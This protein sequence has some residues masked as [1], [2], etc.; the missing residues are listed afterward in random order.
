MNEPRDSATLRFD[1]RVAIVT[2]AGNGLGR[3]HALLLGER[4]AKVVVNDVGTN[5]SGRG[6]A[7][8]PADAVVNEIGTGGGEAVANYESVEDG[9]RIVETALDHFGRIDIVVNNAGILRDRAFHNMTEQEWDEIYRVHVLGAFRVTRAAWPHLRQARY[10]RVVFT[11][12]GS[13]VY[14]NFGQA[15]YAMAKLGLLGLAQTLAVEGRRRNI[16]VNTIAP[17]AGTRMPAMLWPPEVVEALR[18]ELVSPAVVY[19]CHESCAVSGALFEIGGGW[20]ARLRWQRSDGV[21][22]G[23]EGIHA[24]E[25][26]QDHF[27]EI[28]DFAE[29]NNPSSIADAFEPILRN[30]P[31][32]VRLAWAKMQPGRHSANQE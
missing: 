23:P 22:F 7:N 1:D 24:P 20:I 16:M 25:D 17:A 27:D 4:G 6:R 31:E 3:A 28:N 2:G 18:P 32:P 14:G 11:S 13:G 29:A 19:L 15:N 12:S 30:L 26:V 21:Y 5:P 10:G 9:E 8:A